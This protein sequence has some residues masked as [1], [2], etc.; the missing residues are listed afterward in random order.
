MIAT[1][2]ELG[3]VCDALEAFHKVSHWSGV[4]IVRG[5]LEA[6]VGHLIEHGAVFIDRGVLGV[7][8]LPL[9]FNAGTAVCLEVFFWGRGQGRELRKAAE[10]WA[11]DNGCAFIAMA[12]SDARSESFYRRAG[13]EPFGYQYMRSL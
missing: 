9:Y 7:S 6:S 11:A 12:G 4:P 8:R 10:Q 13:Y 1:Q 5:D 2:S 3:R